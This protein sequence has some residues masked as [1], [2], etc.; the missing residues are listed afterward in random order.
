MGEV[1]AD[2]KRPDEALAAIKSQVLA[3]KDRADGIKR[4][5]TWVAD[6]PVNGTTADTYEVRIIDAPADL[7]ILTQEVAV[8]SL[9]GVPARAPVLGDPDS[10]P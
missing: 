1:L 3:L 6:K 10:K 7:V 4:E 9:R 5:V 2:L 8:G